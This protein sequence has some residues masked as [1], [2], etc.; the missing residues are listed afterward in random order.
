MRS[1]RFVAAASRYSGSKGVAVA[2]ATGTRASGVGRP[3][4]RETF[5]PRR[6]L[7][8]APSLARVYPSRSD[9]RTPPGREF[10]WGGTSVKE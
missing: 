2:G 3:G 7:S 9:S 5:G 6:R 4:W 8:S 10:D 1:R